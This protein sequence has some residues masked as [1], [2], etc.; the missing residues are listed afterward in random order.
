DFETVSEWLRAP[1]W[2]S[3]ASMRARLDTWLCQHASIEQDAR[4]LRDLLNE[5]P[6][7]LQAAAR[8]IGAC[9]DLGLRELGSEAATRR[10][11][12]ER[13]HAARDAIGWPG[14]RP[15]ASGEQQTV[16]RLFELLKE[17]GGLG[18][19]ASRWSRSEALSALRELCARTAF[20]PASG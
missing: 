18:A 2:R 12:S 1:Y 17:F 13:M 8:G 9:L 10:Q 11:W 19:V 15:L 20:S 7:A 14:E 3:G 5:A 16:N 6:T 4:S